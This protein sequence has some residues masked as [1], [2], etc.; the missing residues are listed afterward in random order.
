MCVCFQSQTMLFELG[1]GQDYIY[2]H[3][4]GILNFGK[5]IYV[6]IMQLIDL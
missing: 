6:F 4:S 3:Q 1:S 5:H 2:Q